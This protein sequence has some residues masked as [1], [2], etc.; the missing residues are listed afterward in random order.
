MLC[1]SRK[2]SSQ[3]KVDLAQLVVPRVS[4]PHVCQYLIDGTKVLFRG[5]LLDRDPAGFQKA[6]EHELQKYLEETDRTHD[7]LD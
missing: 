5:P 3:A 7:T 6:G 2:F 1:V 4:G